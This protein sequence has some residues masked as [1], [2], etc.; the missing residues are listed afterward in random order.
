MQSHVP[1]L[2]L[3]LPADAA[4]PN[5][6][7]TGLGTVC[8]FASSGGSRD[9]EGRHRELG[10]AASSGCF[11]HSAA[12]MQSSSVSFYGLIA[13]FFFYHCC[14]FF[15]IELKYKQQM[16][17][18]TVCAFSAVALNPCTLLHSCHAGHPAAQFASETVPMRQCPRLAQTPAATILLSVSA[19]LT[20]VHEI[21]QYLSIC[22][23]PRVHKVRPCCRIL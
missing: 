21:T 13:H 16:F 12:Y 10:H 19:I 1:V 14:A 5:P 22:D 4:P 15:Y 2:K 3:C 8:S 6:A 20:R 11:L 23:W 7:A 17:T 9:W 18:G